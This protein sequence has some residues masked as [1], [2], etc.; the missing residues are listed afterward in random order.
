MKKKILS[1]FKK[2]LKDVKFDLLYIKLNDTIYL[3]N[4]CILNSKNYIIFLHQKNNIL[5]YNKNKNILNLFAVL[6]V[7]G[8]HIALH[9]FGSIL[10]YVR[11]VRLL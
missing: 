10:K 9:D 6:E 7:C 4:S 8:F 11:S 5:I 3:L 2:N 1:S